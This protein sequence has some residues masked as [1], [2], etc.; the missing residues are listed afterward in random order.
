VGRGDRDDL[1]KRGERAEME[2][3]IHDRG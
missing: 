1:K 2:F 3:D